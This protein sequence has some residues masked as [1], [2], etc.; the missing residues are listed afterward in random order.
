MSSNV[1]LPFAWLGRWLN[2]VSVGSL[3]LV[4]AVLRFYQLPSLPPGLF[5]DEAKVG[6]QALNLADIGWLPGLTAAD[7]YAPLWIWLQAIS[8]KLFGQQIWALRL[9]PALLGVAAVL[10]TWL[11][12]RE[13]FDRRVAWIAAFTVA[14]TP[15]AL[16]LGRNALVPALIICLAPLTLWLATLAER[17]GTTGW[18]V[19]A[20]LV[21]AL[22]L[23][24]GPLGW[25]IAATVLVLAAIRA[26]QRRELLQLTRPRLA[27]LS[28]LAA[29]FGVL[30]YFVGVSLSSL[31]TLGA[32]AALPGS[33]QSLADSALRTVLMFNL[34]GDENFRHNFAAQPLLNAFL[35][36]MLIAGLLV[37][38][39][40]LHQRRHQ[41]LLLLLLAFLMPP[42][43]STAGAPNAARA[44][45]ALPV[46]AVFVGLG[47]SYMLDLWYRTFPINSAARSTGLVVIA[48]LLVL[49]LFQGYTQYFR[50][51][52]ATNETYIAYN[53]AAVGAARYLQGHKFDGQRYL[54]ATAGEL[55]VAEYLNYRREQYQPLQP[56]QLQGLA[57]GPGA[58]QF[59]VT[60]AVRDEAAK[61]L[62]LKYPGGKL[63]PVLSAF[64]Q[65]EIY[66]VY[67]IAR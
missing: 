3:V 22:D 43:L 63:R 56:E 18:Y 16:T 9:W 13:W 65:N 51:W 7:G 31:K 19:A 49:S 36:L 1:V 15:W 53:E 5:T 12:A 40:R 23:L 20:A 4:A 66:Y 42:L 55:P 44:A 32:L 24:A 33:L 6:L 21:I 26:A 14:T 52:A 67:E 39:S 48:L 17:R 8:V 30:A 29:G 60:A 61:N 10:F 37:A 28:T 64:S 46:V 50:A 58:R 59:I 57:V 27:G 25:L 2:W 54:V 11:W 35:G 41:A 45:A 47:V 38:I 62:S 34:R